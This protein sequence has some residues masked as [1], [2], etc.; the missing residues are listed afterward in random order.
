VALLGLLAVLLLACAAPTTQPTPGASITPTASASA[1][2]SPATSPG[3][4]PTPA[5]SLAPLPAPVTSCPLPQPLPTYPAGYP[6]A[7]Q[8]LPH[9]LCPAQPNG[10]D[11][12][13]FL[14]WLFT[15]I[16][17][18]LFMGLVA[19]YLLTN[20]IGIAIILLTIAIKTVLVP[21]FRRQIVAQRRTQL[22]QPEIRAIQL[23]YKGNRTKIS[24]ETMRMY[25]ERGINPAA[26]CLP[27]VLQLFLLL[28]IYQVVSQGL[29][30]TDISAMLQVFGQPVL[31]VACHAPGTLQPCIDTNIWWLGGLDAHLKSVLFTIF[32]FEM[33]GL[34]VLAALLQLIQTRMMTPASNDPQARAQQRVLLFLPLLVLFWGFLPA[35]LFIYWIVFSAYSIVQQYFIAGWGSLFPLLGWTPGFAKD[36]TP[37]FPV[38]I[39]PPKRPAGGT[40]REAAQT[41]RSPSDRAA[42]TIRPARQRGRTSRRGRRR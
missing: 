31:N 23:K 12:I 6:L 29:A 34:A 4:S 35:G 17:Q 11:P 25:Q 5:G 22:L 39:P 26:G 7:G 14:A 18:I 16:F 13:S 9:P 19:F 21:L 28:P 30:A 27:M 41:S 3:A 1:Q 15:P 38:D 32:G 10:A 24:E 36:H 37:R 8:P 33:S 42:G 40:D 20:D 2:A